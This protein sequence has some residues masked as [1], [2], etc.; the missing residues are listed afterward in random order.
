MPTQE[1]INEI[2]QYLLDFKTGKKEHKQSEWHCGTAHCLAGWKHVDDALTARGAYEVVD[3]YALKDYPSKGDNDS[4]E[5]ALTVWGLW[6]SDKDLFDGG[7]TLTEMAKMLIEIA[8]EHN[9]TTP[10]FVYE[11]AQSED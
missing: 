11:I 6:D 5:Y 10:K 9:L 7:N 2:A 4:E 3:G 8:D 1:H